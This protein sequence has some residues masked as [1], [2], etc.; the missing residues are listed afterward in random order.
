[1]FRN[2]ALT[3]DYAFGAPTKITYYTHIYTHTPPYTINNEG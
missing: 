1:M 3:E 2:T